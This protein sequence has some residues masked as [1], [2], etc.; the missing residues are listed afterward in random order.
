MLNEQQIHLVKQ[1]LGMGGWNDVVKPLVIGRGRDLTKVAMMMPS[2]R[3]EP[4]KDMDDREAMNHIRGRILE[5]EWLVSFFDAEINV[6]DY[7]R[8]RDELDRQTQINNGTE[9]GINHP[10]PS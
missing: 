2:Q 4:Y 5:I 7:N 6:F 8:R 9:V 10:Q 3:P 1:M